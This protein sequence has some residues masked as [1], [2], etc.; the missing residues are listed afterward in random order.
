MTNN[1]KK[2]NIISWV[3]NVGRCN[4]SKNHNI[5]TTTTKR[6]VISKWT[7]TVTRFLHFTCN[8]LQILRLDLHH[9]FSFSGFWTWTGT[10]YTI[11][12]LGSPA[13]PLTLGLVSL[14]NYISQ[15]LIL[16]LFLYMCTSSWFCFSGETWLICR[17]Y[18]RHARL[19]QHLKNQLK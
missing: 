2:C 8:S 9:Q 4:T 3:Y 19:V 10:T 6:L 14:L 18:P 7:C 13:C 16:N 17:V 12:F 15:F 1:N 11:C 5:K